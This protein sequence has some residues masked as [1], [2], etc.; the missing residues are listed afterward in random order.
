MYQAKAEGRNTFQVY[1]ESMDAEARKRAALLASLRKAAERGEFRLQFQ[2]RLRLSDDSIV[3][4]EALLRWRSAELGDIAPAEFIPLAEESGLILPIG[5][6]V[7]A[8]ACRTLRRWRDQGLADISVGINISVLQLLRGDLV[9]FL[10][11]AIRSSG[12]PAD[13]IELEVT[14]SMVMQNALQATTVLNRLRELGVTLAIDDFGTGY[15]SLVYLKRLPIDTLKIDKEF[16]AD[17][18]RDPDDEAITA[19][20]IAMGH[21]LG[22]NV[23]AEGVETPRQLE[24][25]RRQGCDEIQGHWLSPPLD[26]EACLAFMQKR[27]PGMLATG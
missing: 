12:V 19:T 25:L 2:P 26:G 20:I 9:E 3:G 27:L 6:W 24:F 13:R 23:V 15:S 18:H 8:E 16:I 21:S 1:S 17:L 11:A 4:V 10:G 5:E 14:E 7:M 22:L